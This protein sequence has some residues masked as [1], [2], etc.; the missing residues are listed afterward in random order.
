MVLCDIF[1]NSQVISDQKLIQTLNLKINSAAVT[2]HSLSFI[3]F[4]WGG[5]VFFFW[6]G[7]LHRAS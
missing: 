3:I 6:G 5:A 7:G 4:F 2:V 1:Y